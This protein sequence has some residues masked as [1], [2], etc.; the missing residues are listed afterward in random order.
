MNINK[1]IYIY[2]NTYITKLPIVTAKKNRPH[3]SRG[4]VCSSSQGKELISYK[5]APKGQPTLLPLT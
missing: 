2:K 5:I 3:G 1:D 4:T